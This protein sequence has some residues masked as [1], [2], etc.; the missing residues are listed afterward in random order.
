[1]FNSREAVLSFKMLVTAYQI[2][3][4]YNPEDYCMDLHIFVAMEPC[5]LILSSGLPS[6]KHTNKIHIF[7]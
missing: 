3:E 2:T 5:S 1:M 6:V 7:L 4:Y